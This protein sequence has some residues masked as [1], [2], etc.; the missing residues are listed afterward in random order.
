VD[1]GAGKGDLGGLAGGDA[2]EKIDPPGVV[3]YKGKDFIDVSE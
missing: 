2:E 1:G 3:T